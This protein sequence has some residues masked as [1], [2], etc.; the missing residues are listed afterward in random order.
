MTCVPHLSVKWIGAGH[1][2]YSI[3][4]INAYFVCVFSCVLRVPFQVIRAFLWVK[5]VLFD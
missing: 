5:F 3:C 1:R 4:F 2:R